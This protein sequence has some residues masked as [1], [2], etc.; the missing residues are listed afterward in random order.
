MDIK[1]EENEGPSADT[2]ESKTT[3]VG[4]SGLP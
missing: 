3:S 1:E 4:P 2:A